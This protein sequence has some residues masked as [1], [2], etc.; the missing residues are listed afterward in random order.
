MAE[1]ILPA[2]VKATVEGTVRRDES[3]PG[4]IAFSSDEESLWI[5]CPCGCGRITPLDIYGKG[6]PK[7]E[8][9]SWEWDGDRERPTLAPSIHAVGHWHGWLTRGY[10]VQN[11]EDA[12]Q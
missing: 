11:P 4:A 9:P 3:P 8:T 1:R 5:C 6:N 10:F 12:P 7:T 2:P